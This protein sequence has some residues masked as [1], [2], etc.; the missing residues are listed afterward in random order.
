MKTPNFRLYDTQAT[1]GV[2]V[3]IAAI[4][5]LAAL[6]YCSVGR[7]LDLDQGVIAYSPKSPWG[8]YRNYMV[9]GLT[10]VS[11]VLGTAAGL[12]GFNSLGQKRNNR[13]ARSWLGLAMG[14][15][16]DALAPVFFLA[17]WIL[18]ESII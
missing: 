9:M 18:K 12:L 17:W 7:G 11:L 8:Q 5:C 15:F 13:Q 14:A 4:G 1:T 10:A 2:V 6:M 3:G 16:V